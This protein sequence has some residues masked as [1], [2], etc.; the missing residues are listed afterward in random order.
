MKSA[1]APGHLLGLEL[2]LRTVL[3]IFIRKSFKQQ[4]HAAFARGSHPNPPTGLSCESNFGR[5]THISRLGMSFSPPR[6]TSRAP[7]ASARIPSRRRFRGPKLQNRSISSISAEVVEPV[8]EYGP[9]TSGDIFQTEFDPFEDDG[10]D[11]FVDAAQPSASKSQIGLRIY[12]KAS[13]AAYATKFSLSS[14]AIST[15]T[16]LSTDNHWIPIPPPLA[17]FAP[18]SNPHVWPSAEIR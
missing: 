15:Y 13:A 8:D 7:T 17:I 4:L 6:R 5:V 1:D 12:K 3:L 9:D 11:P 2:T 14:G 16:C 10:A 18:K